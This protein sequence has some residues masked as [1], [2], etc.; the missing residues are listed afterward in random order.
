MPP[1]TS[2]SPHARAPSRSAQG[3]KDAPSSA[4]PFPI[5]FD[6]YWSSLMPALWKP[7]LAPAA[8][9]AP[10]RPA[11]SQPTPT[12]P[13]ILWHLATGY[14]ITEWKTRLQLE[15]RPRH[16]GPLAR[17][18][19][20]RRGLRSLATSTRPGGPRG[21]RAHRRRPGT[22]RA[23]CQTPPSAPR[24]SPRP[25]PCSTAIQWNPSASNWP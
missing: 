12:G 20:L 10:P 16:A 8:N 21:G 13:R 4:P 6:H 19:G 3:S 24:S 9:P 25:K 2:P 11:S 17:R 1:P 5:L 7:F 22:C 18:P 15:A 23:C 14:F